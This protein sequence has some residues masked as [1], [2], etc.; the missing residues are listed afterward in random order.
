LER[1]D[2]Q[3]NTPSPILY[4]MA[5][6]ILLFKIELSPLVK[7]VFYNQRVPRN[8][9]SVLP[10]DYGVMYRNENAAQTNKAEGFADDTTVLTM[11]EKSL[12]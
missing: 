6:Q 1:G 7:S 4:N 2:A 12:Y 11:Y 10:A 9:L 8:L 3:G 5:Q